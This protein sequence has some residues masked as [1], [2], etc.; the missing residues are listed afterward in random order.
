[1][2]IFRKQPNDDLD[3]DIDMSDWLEA[4][5]SIVSGVV[6]TPAGIETTGTDI[7]GNI[8]KVWIRGGTDGETYKFSVLITTQSR[9]KEVDFMMVVKDY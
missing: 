3:Y 9:T 8:F 4:G 7:S 2:K 6:T 5:D 1:M